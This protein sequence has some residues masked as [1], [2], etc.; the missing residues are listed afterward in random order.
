MVLNLA[1]TV[2]SI[3]RTPLP[4]SGIHPMEA[5]LRMLSAESQEGSLPGREPRDMVDGTE[6]VMDALKV[7]GV[8]LIIAG[9]AALAYGGFTYTKETHKAD[10][11]PLEI[12]V[13]D[14]EHVNIPVW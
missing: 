5:E 12:K 9:V 7:L 11:G 14:K 6:E 8:I 13:Q 2:P 10:L 3:N 4:T 1:L